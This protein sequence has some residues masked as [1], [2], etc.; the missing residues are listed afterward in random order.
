MLHPPGLVAPRRAAA[1]ISLIA[2]FPSLLSLFELEA[3][4]WQ[5]DGESFL[6]ADATGFAVRT[7]RQAKIAE[8][9]IRERCI[10][11]AVVRDGWKYI[12]VLRDCPVRERRAIAR[13]Y[14]ELVSAMSQGSL[15]TPPLWGEAVREHVYNLDQDAAESVDLAAERPESLSQLRALLANYA[16]Y[17]EH[18]A[19][20][21]ARA[22]PPAKVRDPTTAERLKSLGYL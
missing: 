6:R 10:L 16:A 21:A 11:R 2:L 9:V 8:L 20:E 22:V 5:A 19:L 12:A 1:P 13:A 15:E 7:P 3:G 18:N 4:D 14:P 17:C